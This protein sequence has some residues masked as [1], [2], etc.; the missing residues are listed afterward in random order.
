MRNALERVRLDKV[1]T[2]KVSSSSGIP[3]RTLRR[4]VKFSKDPKSIFFIEEPEESEDENMIVWKPQTAVPMFQI[5]RASTAD[6]PASI[7]RALGS[8][9]VDAAL[10]QDSSNAE[11]PTFCIADK[12]LSAG[13]HFDDLVD[14]DVSGGGLSTP[15]AIY[16]NCALG[17]DTIDSAS[18]QDDSNAAKA[19]HTVNA[20]SAGADVGDFVD[21]SGDG[22]LSISTL[23]ETDVFD[24]SGFDDLFEDFISDDMFDDK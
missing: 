6:A 7:N 3:Q 22:D 23:C 11:V 17:S 18:F 14:I 8:D 19:P 12:N 13:A 5:W 24:N 16:T 2:T 21:V 1:S 10:T 4:Y 20:V 15:K 9:D